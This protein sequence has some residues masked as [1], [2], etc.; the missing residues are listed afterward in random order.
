MAF[1]AI[2]TSAGGRILSSLTST[3]GTTHTFPNLSS[4][5]KNSGDL[6]IA[7]ISR[8]TADVSFSSWGGGFTEFA[9][10]DDAG[11]NAA[12][13]AMAYKWS[14][15]SETGTFT[16]TSSASCQGAMVLMSI[17]GA[18]AS[19]VPEAGGTVWA[20]GVDPDATSLDPGGWGTEDTLWI[21]VGTCAEVNSAGAFNAI[22]T[23]T[24]TNYSNLFE[25]GIS[26]D[27]VGG[28]ELAVAFRQ[29][30]AASENPTAWTTDTSNTHAAATCI[31]V[32]P[33]AAAQQKTITNATE[34]DVAQ[35]LRVP[36]LTPATETDAAQAL[37]TDKHVKLSGISPPTVASGRILKSLNSSATTTQT[38]PNLSG[39]T[40]QAG[41]LLILVVCQAGSGSGTNFSGWTGGFTEFG[42]ISDTFTTSIGAAYKISDGTETGAPTVTSVG[43]GVS[44]C[45]AIAI[46]GAHA[47]TIPEF[48]GSS[49][50]LNVAPD[51]PSLNPSGWDGEAL[52]IAVGVEQNNSGTLT[53]ISDPP[54]FFSEFVSDIA[55]T[56]GA[57][58]IA[59]FHAEVATINPGAFTADTTDVFARGATIAVRARTPVLETNTAQPLNVD[60]QKTLGVATETDAAQPLSVT[61]TIFKTITPAVETDAAQILSFSQG[62]GAQNVTILPATE[63]DTAQALNVDKQK[64]LGV[65]A[66]TDVAQPLSITK[67]IFK[68]ITPAVESDTAQALN[69]DKRKQL[70]SAAE[71]DVAQP[72]SFT[73]TIRKT[74]TPA[75]ETD[76]AQPLSITHP[77]I[78][79]INPAVTTDTAQPLS[80]TK[81]ASTPSEVIAVNTP[82]VA[83]PTVSVAAPTVAVVTASSPTAVTVSVTQPDTPEVDV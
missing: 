81:V 50:S 4:L 42:D 51:P 26:A 12:G 39:L 36:K 38:F 61:K 16:V 32:R 67:T 14:T 21:N 53:G 69:V 3:S 44:V 1:P 59:F 83:K 33:A 82:T 66:E 10:L 43:T 28:T 18:H 62:G 15:G 37:N 46:P 76:T 27:V 29:L 31:A 65:A 70:G 73:K 7:I 19:T 34:T 55:G 48:A 63:T 71:T 74:L 52:W 64:T 20:S 49:Q 41:D 45:F 6:L 17:S 40:K 72:L 24:P 68:T 5:T 25:T 56:S 77:I 30:N 35:P 78:K 60:K 23:T 75:V 22:S 2:P 9:D 79:T 58:A 47:S 11:S 57:G 54:T 80:F 8:G 13:F